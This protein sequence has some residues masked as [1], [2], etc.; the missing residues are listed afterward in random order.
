M[1]W[2]VTGCLVAVKRN[3]PLTDVLRDNLADDTV[4]EM[5]GLVISMEDSQVNLEIKQRLR[6]ALFI[7][8]RTSFHQTV[9]LTLFIRRKFPSGNM[10]LI[11]EHCRN[12]I[13]IKVTLIF[14][15]F[16]AS[17]HVILCIFVKHI[18]LFLQS[19]LFI[20]DTILWLLDILD[21]HEHVKPPYHPI[22]IGQS[23]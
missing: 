13:N 12:G 9:I 8:F 3:F 21:N 15:P 22:C 2:L 23:A 6:D 16:C 11:G 14:S 17:F 10:S 18:D 5:G 20:F 4:Q 7:G 1:L 19:M